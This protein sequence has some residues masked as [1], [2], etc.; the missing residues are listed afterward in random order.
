MRMKALSGSV[1]KGGCVMGES[2][3]M[4]GWESVSVWMGKKLNGCINVKD[5]VTEWVQ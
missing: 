3:W 5:W 2:L 4:N 1:S